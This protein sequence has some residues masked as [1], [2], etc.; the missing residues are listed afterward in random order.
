MGRPSVS[1]SPLPVGDGLGGVVDRHTVGV[2]QV[3]DPL[4]SGFLLG[5]LDPLAPTSRWRTVHAHLP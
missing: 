1:T 2:G 3:Q 5:G 4:P